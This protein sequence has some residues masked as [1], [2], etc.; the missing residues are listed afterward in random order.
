MIAARW[1]ADGSG[2]HDRIQIRWNSVA[3]PLLLQLVDAED[4][5]TTVWTIACTHL[6][7]VD[8]MDKEYAM[9]ASHNHSVVGSIPTGPTIRLLTC[10]KEPVVRISKAWF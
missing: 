5:G 7:W 10:A 6:H 1:L 8:A 2:I 3:T 4:F 9:R